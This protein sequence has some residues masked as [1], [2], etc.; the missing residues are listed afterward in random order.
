MYRKSIYIQKKGSGVVI[1]D[2]SF[3]GN[4][5][6]L[7]RIGFTRRI[8]KYREKLGKELWPV[9]RVR[10]FQIFV[11]SATLSVVAHII[12]LLILSLFW[13]VYG[14]GELQGFPQPFFLI[15]QY[16]FRPGKNRKWICQ[17]SRLRIRSIL[18][19][20]SYRRTSASHPQNRQP[21]HWLRT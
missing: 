3:C 8:G 2:E 14:C 19:C 20:G 6:L 16:F 15:R 12:S 7:K 1:G 17:I 9:R 13:K 11:V 21:Y 5:M 4:R 18:K 10:T